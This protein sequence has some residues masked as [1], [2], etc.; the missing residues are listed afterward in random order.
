MNEKSKIFVVIGAVV[1]FFA[2]IIGYSINFNIKSNK[3]YKVFEDSYNKEEESIVLIGRDGCSWCQLFKPILDFYKEKYDFS[4]EYLDTDKLS[5]KDLAKILDKLEVSDDDFGT[6][7]LGFVKRGDVTDTIIGYTD[8]REL[9]AEL[10]KYGFVNE[11]EKVLVNYL[12]DFKSIKGTFKNKDKEIIVIG[13]TSCSYCIMFKPVLMS[14]V[15]KY[16]VKINYMNYN[17]IKEQEELGKY[18]EQYEQFKGDWG[19]PMTLIVQNEKIID[20]FN[21]Y[22]TE[23]NYIKFL[24]KNGF[25]EE[26]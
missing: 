4:Y 9:L 6:P 20:V 16:N 25:I 1:A 17:E 19:T 13:Q 8:E 12:N 21:G 23:T 2:I 18:L 14:I 10:Q 5:K 26:E 15:D 3:I 24:E 22:G 7:L 11:N